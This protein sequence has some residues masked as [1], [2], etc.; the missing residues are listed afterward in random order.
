VRPEP[1]N[2]ADQWN[3]LKKGER[4]ERVDLKSEFLEG[5]LQIIVKLANVHLTPDK[6]SYAG[7]TWHVEGQLVR[8]HSLITFGDGSCWFA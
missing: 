1:G 2:F 3:Y 7:G 4:G 5:G 6:P 8:P